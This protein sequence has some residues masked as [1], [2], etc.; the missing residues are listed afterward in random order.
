MGKDELGLVD[1]AAAAPAA[2]AVTSG[3]NMAH[4]RESCRVMPLEWRWRR[5]RTIEFII[6]CSVDRGGPGI[7]S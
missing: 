6:I 5:K 3:S 7:G 1:D 2:T 4:G